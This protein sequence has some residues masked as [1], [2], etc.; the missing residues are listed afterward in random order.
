MRPRPAKKPRRERRPLFSKTKF[1]QNQPEIKKHAKNVRF[2]MDLINKK[3]TGNK[4]VKRFEKV[5]ENERLCISELREE[6][7]KR[8]PVSLVLWDKLKGALKRV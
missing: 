6:A 1:L 5:L 2:L 8:K 7:E 4:T 3:S